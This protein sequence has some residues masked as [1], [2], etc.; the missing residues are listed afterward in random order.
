MNKV[1]I[2]F[3]IGSL[4]IGGAEKSLVNLL[5]LLDY[6][7]IDAEVVVF[8]KNGTLESS[9][10]KEVKITHISMPSLP[11][12]KKI[13]YIIER[14]R[15]RN[16]HPVQIHWK[17]I[18]KLFS[19]IE[20]KYDIG[21]AYNQGFATYFTATYIK[22]NRKFFWLNS[23]YI[24]AKYDV[25][26][27]IPYFKKYDKV[28]AVTEFAHSTL[29]KSIETRGFQIPITIIKDISNKKSILELSTKQQTPAF[30]KNYIN[31]TTI[32][33]LVPPKGLELAVSAC[34]ILVD[35]GYPIKW[36]I[37]G[38]GPERKKLEILINKNKLNEHL[39]LLG[40]KGNPYNFV[41]NSDIYVQTS[42]FEGLGLTLIEAKYL[43]KPIVTTDFDTAF[44][45]IENSET[46]LIVSK[47]PI[48][49]SNGV[50]KIINDASLKEKLV[51]NLNKQ[52]DNDTE[53]SLN[54]FN[55]LVFDE[56]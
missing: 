12:G 34:R 49:I 44:E 16:T 18:K 21:I 7:R 11:L 27:D 23:D 46:G 51:S 13:R 55:S 37:I 19:P 20:K 33:R 36:H 39:F 42:L 5:Q 8:V 43:L 40:A 9:V 15:K 17:Y 56:N 3:V 22:S 38:E 30:N 28:V 6:N 10:P 45:L 24:K 4:N 25:D 54:S 52:S 31:I 32:G 48:S 1:S 26:L 53:V 35:R 41:K 14:L 50:E 29:Q 47:D 2:V